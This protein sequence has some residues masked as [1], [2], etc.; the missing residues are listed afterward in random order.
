MKNWP[1]RIGFV[2]I[3]IIIAVAWWQFYRPEQSMPVQVAA[4][5]PA[6]KPAAKPVTQHPVTADVTEIEAAKPV[7]DLE[8]PLP[9]LKQSDTPMAE[10]LAKLFADQNLDRFFI[11]EHFIERFVVMID[12]LPRPQLSKTHRP[13]KQTPGRFL[14]EGERD[15]LSI[16]PANYRRYTPLVKMLG[17]LDPRQVA[18]IYKHLYPLFQ[19][20]YEGL[21]YPNAYFNDRLVEVIDHLLTTPPTADPVYLVQPKALYLFADPDI[22]ALSAG[23]KILIRSGP[24]NAAQIKAMLHE[25]RSELATH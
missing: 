9:E 11:L 1:F 13:L 3:G 20:A 24:E 6:S 25:Y 19:E 12:N 14:A 4:P 10:I 17:T 15:Q 7:I 8:Q 5:P 23:R 18:A 21:G 2:V 22:E 16:A